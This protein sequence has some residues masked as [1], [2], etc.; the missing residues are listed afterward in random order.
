MATG[1]FELHNTIACRSVEDE[2]R[3]EDVCQ[4]YKLKPIRVL[5][6]YDKRY[7]SEK[8]LLA[9]RYDP[10]GYILSEWDTR[11]LL[12]TSKYVTGDPV[13]AID[14]LEKIT[15]LL[16]HEGFDVIREKVEAVRSSIIIDLPETSY[17]ETHVVVTTPDCSNG[18]FQK[19]RE[20]NDRI[21]YDLLSRHSTFVPLSVNMK[22]MEMNEVF[23]TLRHYLSDTSSLELD[24]LVS[25]ANQTIA[26][27]FPILK[28][29]KETVLYDTNPL[30][31]AQFRKDLEKSELLV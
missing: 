24:N 29:I 10:K 3:F 7:Q 6:L 22:K 23:I 5:I 2:E 20:L 17:Y 31:D 12:Q 30:V 13:C 11:F 16:K 27:E 26:K 21:N 1:I 15:S 9:T 25:I 18:T 14:E 8:N 4:K 28:T 19:L